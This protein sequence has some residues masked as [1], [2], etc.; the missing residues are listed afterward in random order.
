MILFLLM[1]K[2]KKAVK[3]ID[4]VV[5]ATVMTKNFDGKKNRRNIGR[6]R[7]ARLDNRL[8]SESLGKLSKNFPKNPK[9]L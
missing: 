6:L 2:L 9:K 8:I 1:K 4:T 7:S 5:T 3:S